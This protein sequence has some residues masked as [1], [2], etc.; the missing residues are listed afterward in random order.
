MIGEAFTTVK[1][2]MQPLRPVL[3]WPPVMN[4]ASGKPPAKTQSVRIDDVSK[5]ITGEILL[6]LFTDEN[7][8]L[9]VQLSV[10]SCRLSLCIVHTIDVQLTSVLSSGIKRI[11]CVEACDWS[12]Q[13]EAWPIYDVNTNLVATIACFRPSLIRSFERISAIP[14]PSSKLETKLQLISHMLH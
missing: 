1:S 7:I 13:L 12:I 10:T 11:R 8:S 4:D 5:R 9:Y 2:V 6:L 14:L 3:C